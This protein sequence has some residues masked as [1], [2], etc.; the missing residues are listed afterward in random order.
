[1]SK[2]RENA[3]DPWCI[4]FF[5]DNELGWGND[6]SLSAAALVSPPNSNG[7]VQPAKIAVVDM[8]RKKYETIE[9]FNTAWKTSY[10]DWDALLTATHAPDTEN[11]DVKA[12]L[13][14]GYS[15]IAEEYF[16]VIRD[17][18][19]KV[20]PNTLYFG[21]RFAWVND[22]AVRAADKFC[23][24]LSFNVYEYDLSGF[25]LPKGVDKGVMIGE[26]HFGA[27]DRGMLHTGLCPTANQRDRA[28][29]YEK[30]VRSG[31][32]H[33]NIV[34]TRWFLYS[35][36]A[37]TGRGGDGENYQI[38]L[39]DV[40]DTPYPETIDAVK[41]IGDAMYDIRREREK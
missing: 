10:A 41:R 18:L 16:R 26:F 36:Q 15:L 9:K 7:D 23:E 25:K 31:L 1:M 27:L 32:T 5:V 33:P 38:G 35:D 6:T 4:G 20:A 17:E 21:C 24:V 3:N 34:G 39:V 29:A 11:K 12:D 22:R 13:Q 28:A 30:Y 2:Q 14:A 19:K 8:L 37:T 40:C